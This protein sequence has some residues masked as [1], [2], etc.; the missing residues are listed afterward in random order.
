MRFTVGK[1][2]VVMTE[3]AG[4]LGVLGNFVELGNLL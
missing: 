4:S 3:L 2:V 1:L